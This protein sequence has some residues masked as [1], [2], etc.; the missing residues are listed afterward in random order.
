[1][2]NAKVAAVTLMGQKHKNREVPCEDYSIA[3]EGNGVSVVVVSDGA[4]GKEYTHARFGSKATC[5]MISE[6]LINHFDAIYNENREA[7]IK[8]LLITAVYSKMADI[9]EEM[10]LDSLERLSCTMLFCAVKD[11]RVICGHI[12]DGLIV[13]VSS[14]GVSPIT[15]PQN[16]QNASSTYFITAN[17]AADYMRLI[18]T[19]VDDI[20]GIALM[21]DGVQDMVYD[22]NSG[23]VKPVIAKMVDTLKGTREECENQI[24][25]ILDKFVVGASNM[26]DDASFG[27]ILFDDT[28]SPNTGSLPTAKEAFPRNYED[29]FKNLQNELLPK[30]KHAKNVIMNASTKKLDNEADNQVSDEGNGQVQGNIESNDSATSETKVVE[31]NKSK[32]ASKNSEAKGKLGSGFLLGV[33]V[34]AVCAAAIMSIVFWLIPH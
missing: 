32:D 33:L 4:G 31:N 7:A 27:I 13:R 12:G 9:I 23:L 21:T 6:L 15:M 25:S 20:H 18:K 22:E 2:S 19:T 14:S 28:T 29:S 11:R 24:T 26:S 34:G 5:E 17:H 8:S 10:S 30:V 3:T 16:G 1:M